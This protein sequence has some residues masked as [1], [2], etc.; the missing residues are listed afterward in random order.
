MLAFLRLYSS[1]NGPTWHEASLLAATA[2]G[3]GAGLARSLQMWVWEYLEDNEQ[4][5]TSLYGQHR[6]K[7]YLHAMDIIRYLD[8]PEMHTMEY[9]YGKPQNGMYVDDHE[10]ADVV[11]YRTAVFLPFWAGIEDRM[12]TWSKDNQPSYP[13]GMPTFPQQKQVVLVTHDESTF[14]ANDRRKMR[15][16]HISEKPEPVCKGEGTSL[17]VSDFCSPDL[18]WLKSKDGSQ[19]AR[20]ERAIELFEDNYPGT[21]VA[22]FRF[23]N[24]PGH[25]KRADN[26]L[27]AQYM[28]KLAK[29][30][31]GKNGKCRM[32][33][34][35]LPNGQP[36]EF[37]FP[38]D[39]P[40]T[41][42]YF[43]GMKLILEERGF[44]EE[45]DKWAE[46]PA[47][48]CENTK[49][50]CCCQQI[51]FNQQDFS[52][53]HI[54]F[55]YPKF[56]CELNFIEQC[57]GAAKY[58]Y[59]MLP[60]TSNEAQMERNVR[61]SLDSVDI[62]KIRRLIHYTY[63][64]CSA[65]FMHAYRSGLDGTMAAWANKRFHRHRVLPDTLMKS[66]EKSTK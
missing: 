18:G 32:R 23:D 13:R 28:P 10:R 2:A 51:L 57:W 44:T 11:E 38:D 27:S 33:N 48:K 12:M 49:A 56:H 41:P 9:R 8:H 55:F 53:G 64:N 21:A 54:A 63:A 36:Q 50:A 3:K 6:R 31:H 60:P 40:T 34:G 39:H 24:A 66:L 16:V 17:M 5:P 46:C 29:H 42:G 30:W 65:Q 62:L 4:L 52:H 35:T 45:S 19:E 1:A 7:T 59:R 61:E 47:F 26:A 20:T 37:Y 25:Q 15:W 22:A 14:Y 58:R 43:K